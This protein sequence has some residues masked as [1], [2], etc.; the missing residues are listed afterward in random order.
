MASPSVEITYDAEIGARHLT[1]GV[2]ICHQDAYA[3][4][5]KL[6]FDE[7]RR[8][9]IAQTRGDDDGRTRVFEF[10][11]DAGVEAG[12]ITQYG[13]DRADRPGVMPVHTGHGARAHAM[14]L[15]YI[16]ERGG[17]LMSRPVIPCDG[18]E[19]TGALPVGE[20]TP[21]S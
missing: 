4:I 13:I 16:A 11:Y 2:P 10:P 21:A 18:R 7:D 14:A 15:A 5:T 9:V 8:R 19:C 3:T 1:V 6:I 12:V 17:T 20:F